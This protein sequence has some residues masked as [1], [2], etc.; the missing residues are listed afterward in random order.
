[1]K[2]REMFE[3]DIK[4]P[5]NGVVQVEQEQE[6]VVKQEVKEYVVTT[7]L[8]NILLSSLMNIVNLL[9]SLLIMLV[10]GLQGSLEVVNHTS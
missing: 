6:S 1:M 7:E 4:R 9:M 3:E 2:I 5:I 10:Y 8:K